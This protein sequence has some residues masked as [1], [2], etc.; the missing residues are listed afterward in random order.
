MGALPM[1]E[2]SEVIAFFDASFTV[3]LGN[4]AQTLLWEDPWIQG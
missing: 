2:D 3:N 4:G 1:R